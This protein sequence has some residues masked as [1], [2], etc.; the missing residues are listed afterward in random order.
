[1]KRINISALLG[2]EKT[3]EYESD[4]YTNSNWC[5]WYSPQ[6]INNETGGHGNKRS[7]GDHSSYYIIDNCLEYREESRRLGDLLSLKLQ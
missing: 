4:A 3:N 2:I 5:S 7:S 6:R 1:M